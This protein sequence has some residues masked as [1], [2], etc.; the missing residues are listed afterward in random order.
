MADHFYRS[1]NLLKAPKDSGYECTGF[2]IFQQNITKKE[3]L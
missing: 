2:M 3:I 1:Q